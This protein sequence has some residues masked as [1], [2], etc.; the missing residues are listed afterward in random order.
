MLKP[1]YFKSLLSVL[2]FSHK[3]FLL[4]GHLHKRI[5]TEAYKQNQE[6]WDTLLTGLE[7]GTLLG[8]ENILEKADFFGKPFSTSELNNIA[9]KIKNIRK[10]LIAHSD[11]SVLQNKK[12]FLDLNKLHGTD[13]IKIITA[14]KER[15]IKYQ[16]LYKTDDDVAKLFEVATRITL[17]D[18]DN[19]LKSFKEPL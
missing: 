11:L 2:L 12:S 8:L 10:K 1:K 19:W 13:I 6:T 15:A 17:I 16:E 14:L 18:L 3:Q 5:H 7:E 9:K 4:H